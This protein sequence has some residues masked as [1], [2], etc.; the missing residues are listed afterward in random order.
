M[1]TKKTKTQK[2]KELKAKNCQM[3]LK[4]LKP[5]EK[6]FGKEQLR[7][8]LNRWSKEMGLR[9]SLLK[10]KEEIEEQLKDIGFNKLYI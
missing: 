3:I 6:K 1:V 2:I 8:A 5:L 9:Q 7:W 4:A 10:Q